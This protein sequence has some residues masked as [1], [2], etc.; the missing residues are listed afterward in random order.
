MNLFTSK[1]HFA[2][3]FVFFLVFTLSCS[4]PNSKIGGVGKNASIAAIQ[5]RGK[6]VAVIENSGLSF[7]VD[8]GQPMGYQYEMLSALARTIGVPLE[9]LPVDN[10]SEGYQLLKDGKCDIL[11]MNLVPNKTLIRKFSFTIPHSE[12]MLASVSKSDTVSNM[13][14][15]LTGELAQLSGLKATVGSKSELVKTT[16]HSADDLLEQVSVGAIDQVIVSYAQARIGELRYPSLKVTPIPTLHEDACW[17]VN[18]DSR[19]LL[20]EINSWL[21]LYLKSYSYKQMALK[22]LQDDGVYNRYADALLNRGDNAFSKFDKEI[23]H[24][25]DKLGWDWR[26]LASVIFQESRFKPNVTSQAGAYGL[27]QIMPI[28]AQHFGAVDIVS[29]KNN[30]R[31]GVMLLSKLEQHFEDDGIAEHER[32]KFVLGAYNAGLG[33]IEDARRLTDKYH[34]NPDSWRDVE[35]FLKK[36]SDPK[37]YR[38]PLVKYGRFTG[39]ETSNFVAEVLERYGH[40]RSLAMN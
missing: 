30:I 11:A 5:H 4:Q 12:L 26:L 35:Y 37:Y 3:F 38:D 25:S 1:N 6:L 40:Y 13:T 9:L 21:L 8:K 27:M 19:V 29:P 28:T 39:V 7:F 20:E 33:H 15:Y 16:E 10:A 17:A 36:K 2:A 24:F 18:R 14:V 23:K 34:R 32:I 22:Y 31:V